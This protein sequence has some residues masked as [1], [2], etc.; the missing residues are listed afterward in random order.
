MDFRVN[1]YDSD[2]KVVDSKVFNRMTDNE[3]I[4][5]AT[6]FFLECE[7]TSEGQASWYTIRPSD[8][9]DRNPNG[10]PAHFDLQ[11]RKKSDAAEVM[12]RLVAIEE[13][14][15][16]IEKE[17]TVLE[18]AYFVISQAAEK[19]KLKEV[20]ALATSQMSVLE[21]QNLTTVASRISAEIDLKN[22]EIAEAGM[23]IADLIA[24]WKSE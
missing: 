3:I 20:V 24:S 8:N 11:E 17:V 23:V 10:K 22:I 6:E 1:V 18:E 14:R 2:N 7:E 15:K 16:R 4:D 12:N 5:A 19:F 9:P 21:L 13:R